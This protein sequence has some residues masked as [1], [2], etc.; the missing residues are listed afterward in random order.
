MVK[1]EK[2][3]IKEILTLIEA[4][5]KAEAKGKVSDKKD[6]I[7]LT[8]VFGISLDELLRSSKKDLKARAKE[9]DLNLIVPIEKLKEPPKNLLEQ[10]TGTNDIPKESQNKHKKEDYDS[11]YESTNDLYQQDQYVLQTGEQESG[12]HYDSQTKKKKKQQFI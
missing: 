7:K 2:L 11:K 5:E 12:W 1:I 8:K 10:I 9:Y 4:L 6:A 3:T